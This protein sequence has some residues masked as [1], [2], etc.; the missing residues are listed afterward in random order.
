[1]SIVFKIVESHQAKLEVESELG[2][3]TKFKLILNKK[4]EL[5]LN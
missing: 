3:G 5:N 2:V 1:M 4:L